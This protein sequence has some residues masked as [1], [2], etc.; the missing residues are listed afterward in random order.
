MH[1]EHVPLVDSFVF[2]GP[3]AV[4]ATVDLDVT[5]RADGGVEHFRPGSS[6]PL[7]PTNFAAEFRPALATGSFA[8]ES[9]GL[10]FSGNASSDGIFGEMGHERNGVFVAG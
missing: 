9:R 2:L 3:D 4:P 6:D 10:E 1:L 8:G 7:D 5:W